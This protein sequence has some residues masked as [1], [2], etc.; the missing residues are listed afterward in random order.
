MSSP[1]KKR[2]PSCGF[3]ANDKTGPEEIGAVLENVKND[4]VL[5][6]KSITSTFAIY[7]VNFFKV[8]MPAT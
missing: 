2:H 4:D 7:K 8:H 1:T 6:A 5:F 3:P